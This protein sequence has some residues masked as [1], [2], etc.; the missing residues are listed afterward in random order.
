MFVSRWHKKSD[1]KIVIF[2]DRMTK[3]LTEFTNKTINTMKK[4]F[5]LLLSTIVCFTISSCQKYKEN[6]RDITSQLVTAMNT[7]NN[8]E[9]NNSDVSFPENPFDEA[10]I[11]HNELITNILNEGYWKD[12]SLKFIE[13]FN[14]HTNFNIQNLNIFRQI[15]NDCY[16]L[17][18]DENGNYSNDFVNQLENI[19]ELEKQT[20]NIFFTEMEKYEDYS[21]KIYASKNA[22]IFILDNQ[23]YTSS[24]RER[25]LSAMAIYRYS[26]YLWH[27]ILP[28]EEKGRCSWEDVYSKFDAL[29]VYVATQTFYPELVG[30]EI[31]DGK[32]VNYFSASVSLSAA[33]TF[34]F[35]PCWLF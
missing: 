21:D 30:I 6:T 16:P 25:L 29:G 22:E 33:I 31:Q 9:K 18:F 11:I 17:A 34:T 26:L 2:F 32:D 12:D 15:M 19:P 20:L 24:M 14:L 23:D 4:I 28:N 3:E 10:G 1:A 13:G 7:L 8:P 27:T 35:I 5:V